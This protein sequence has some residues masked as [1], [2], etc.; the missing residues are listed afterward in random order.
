MITGKDNFTV[1]FHLRN[2]R[3]SNERLK[4][5]YT[6]IAINSTRMELSVKQSIDCQLW[7][8]K[9]G[10]ARPANAECRALNNFL[11]QLRSSYVECYRQMVLQKKEITLL[12]FKNQYFGIVDEQHAISSLIKYHNVDMQH[13]I[14]RGTMKN[15]YT[16]KKYIEQFLIEKQQKPDIAL[17]PTIYDWIKHGKLKRVKIRSRVYFLGSDIR[18]LMC[19]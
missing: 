18:Q 14:S 3:G 1:L 11:E 7:D 4:N 19:S 16:T 5:I 8:E 6:R 17:I 2:N 15:Y 10:T 13:S 12:T 9:R